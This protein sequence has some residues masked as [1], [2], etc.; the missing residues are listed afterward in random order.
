MVAL[1]VRRR[2]DIAE[3]KSGNLLGLDTGEARGIAHCRPLIPLRP[4]HLVSTGHWSANPYAIANMIIARLYHHIAYQALIDEPA[5]SCVRADKT[6]TS[7]LF[8]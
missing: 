5:A 3:A 1:C 6:C 8:S 7:Y 2:A 4:L